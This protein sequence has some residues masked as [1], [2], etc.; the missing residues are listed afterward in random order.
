MFQLIYSSKTSI[1]KIFVVFIF[2]TLFYGCISSDEKQ[3]SEIQSNIEPQK[4]EINRT[5]SKEFKNYWYAGIAEITSYQLV[6]ERYGELRKGIAVTIFVTEDFLADAQVKANNPTFND[7]PVLK[8]NATK[9]FNTGIYPYT[10]MSSTFSPVNTSAHAL[11]ISNTVQEWCGQTFMQLNNRSKFEITSHSYFEGESD[12]NL[13]LPKTWLENEFWNLIRI[14]PEEL[15]TGDISVIPSFEFISL[16]HKEIK[17]YPA[18]AS[19]KQGDSISSFSL[20]YPDL[21]RELILYFNSKFPYEIEK[22]EETN[23]SSKAD[24]LQLKTTATKIKS[25]RT[26]YWE[27]NRNEDSHLRDSLNLN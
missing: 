2:G 11:K 12:Q 26:A 20:N 10:I 24:T 23:A 25:I 5:I 13:S 27:Q 16:R 4:T 8:L 14:N 1:L 21:K 22:W 17:A 15:P 7:I 6:Q 9:N 18:F 3:K 19:L